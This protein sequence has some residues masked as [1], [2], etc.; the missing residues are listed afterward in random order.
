MDDDSYD[1]FC[2][3]CNIYVE[4]KV[5][6]HGDGGYQ[7]SAINPLD[8]ADSPYHVVSYLIALC[9]RCDNP[10]LIRKTIYGVPGDFET[11]VEN[12]VLF[13]VSKLRDFE[14][15]PRSI[16]RALDQAYRAFSTS[17]YEACALM[18]RRALEALC[19]TYSATGRNLSE[20]VDNL[21]TKGHIDSKLTEWAHGVRLIG[22]DAAHDVDA[23]IARQ[24]ARDILDLTEALLMYIFT[25]DVKFQ[26][27]ES[28]RKGSGDTANPEKS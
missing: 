4:A 24:D 28:R 7:S 5:I 25:L 12:T 2:P 17:S 6:A 22:N 23:E 20:R 15:L 3:N 18:C 8:E 16:G 13:P 11:E 10:F 1:L 14:G 21:K 26:A 19:K 9:R 27:Y